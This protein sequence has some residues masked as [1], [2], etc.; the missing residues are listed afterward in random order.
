MTKPRAK[1]PPT[2]HRR[3]IYKTYTRRSINTHKSEIP[4][5]GGGGASTSCHTTAAC[6]DKHVSNMS[7]RQPL[8]KDFAWPL[9]DRHHREKKMCVV[10][11]CVRKLEQLRLW[12]PKSW[13]SGRNNQ[14]PQ[15]K[16]ANEHSK[17]FGHASA[18]ADDQPH[19]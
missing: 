16:H 15:T 4:P 2:P 13:L 10:E 14:K 7:P 9:Q 6:G 19:L 3:N 8:E 18:A 5:Y 11:N 12:A 17:R 1:L